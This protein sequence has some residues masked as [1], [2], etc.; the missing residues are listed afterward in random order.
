M[1]APN[2]EV[3]RAL[4]KL[5]HEQR[6]ASLATLGRGGPQASMVAYVAEPD[7]GGVLM[8]LSRLASHTRNLLAD[9]RAALAIS[10][11]DQG[12]GDP[13]TLARISIQ[14]TAIALEPHTRDFERA[15][16]LYI[17]RLPYAEERFGF[18]DFTV[19]RLVP[20]TA[21]YVGGFARAYSLGADALRAC[22]AEHG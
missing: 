6:W 13:Q 3:G 8:H 14:G 12:V 10:E 9:P 4:L 17:D 5:I 18:G 20:V 11:P 7:L 19:W 2:A 21:R 15:R 22:A 1:V 16:A